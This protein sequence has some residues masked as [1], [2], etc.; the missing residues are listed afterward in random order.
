M[1]SSH[2]AGND[3]IRLID[4]HIISRGK[5]SSR[6][7]GQVV[8]WKDEQGYGFITPRGGGKDIFVH[9]NDFRSRGRRPAIGAIV[10][11]RLALDDKQRQTATEVH[12]HDE[13]DT[14]EGTAHRSPLIVAFAIGFL[15]LI[16]ILGLL[17]DLPAVVYAGVLGT[18]LVSVLLYG[19]D[20]WSAKTGGWRVPEATL[21]F[22]ALIGGWP[23]ALVAQTLFHHKT[24][25][26]S[27]RET[28]WIT[29]IVNCI[30]ITAVL[31]MALRAKW[32]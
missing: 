13:P 32:E 3:G 8:V 4:L 26:R 27:F 10:T 25:K 12:Y 5:Q 7:T 6:Y 20:K 17:R 1:G 29:V 30:A 24:T 14:G 2:F 9:V 19:L 22:W 23:G 28:F 31:M 11:Y 21:H 18:S 15:V 16:G